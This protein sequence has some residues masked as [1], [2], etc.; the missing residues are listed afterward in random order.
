MT[1][2]KTLTEPGWLAEINAALAVSVAG[3]DPSR[4]V[5]GYVRISRDEKD[6]AEGVQLQAKSQV[7]HAERKGLALARIVCDNDLS[8]ADADRPGLG[9]L[10][11]LVTAGPSKTALARDVARLTRDYDLGNELMKLG[12]DEDVRYLFVKDSEYDLTTG[13]GRK[14][15]MVKVAEAAEYREVNTENLLDRMSE[16]AAKGVMQGGSRRFGYGR[17]V[18]A[19]PLTGADVLDRNALRES[20]VAVLH[21]GRDRVLNG[22]SQT[23]IITDWNRR[24]ITAA[25]GGLWRVGQLARQLLLEAYVAYDLGEHTDVHG[26]RCA[27]LDNPEGNGIRVH[28]RTGTRHRAQWPAVFTRAEHDA[29]RAGLRVHRRATDKDR[30]RQRNGEYWLTGLVECG[31]TWAEVSGRAGEDCGSWMVGST[32]E[33]KRKNGGK[34]IQRRYG[35]PQ[36]NAARQVC[37]CGRVFR[38]AGALETY[39][40]QAVIAVYEDPQIIARLDRGNDNAERIAGLQKRIEVT[41]GNLDAEADQ[42]A[43]VLSG[44]GDDYDLRVIERTIANLKQTLKDLRAEQ[45]SLRSAQ[46]LAVL[47]DIGETGELRKA[48]NSKGSRWQHEAAER[49]IEKVIVRPAR[50]YAAK[51]EDQNRKTWR[52]DKSSV[53]IVWREF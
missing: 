32:L 27:C 22:E 43:A 20:E 10:L 13:A 23:T 26:R 46:A 2:T 40:A 34:A 36:K 8:G 31:G 9:E 53:E 37:G 48:W 45:D 38:D 1:R 25:G 33:R 24:G 39:V 28:A 49:L 44:A 15:F 50:I 16:E 3:I 42:R 12:R 6:R 51:W 14:N 19:H 52:F 41:A 5:Y 18:G 47:A 35:C 29:M 11:R 30:P 17:V 21:E 7:A 4:W